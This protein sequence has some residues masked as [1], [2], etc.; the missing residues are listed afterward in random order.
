MKKCVIL[1][2]VL[3]FLSFPISSFGEIGIMGLKSKDIE[4]DFF[5][6]LKTYPTFMR[7]VDFNSNATKYDFILDENGAMADHSIRNELRIGWKGK[8]ENWDFLII[9]EGDFNLNK[10]NCDRGSD[11]TAA[12]FADDSG[13]SGEDFGIEK[14]NF[15]YDF[16]PFAVETGWNT[17]FLDIMTGGFLYGD[18]HP[19]IGLTGNIGSDFYW[20]LL[21]LIIQDDIDWDG[22]EGNINDGDSLDWRVYSIKGI[23]KLPDNFVISPFFAYSDNSGQRKGATN[24]TQSDVCFFGVEAY[25]QINIFTPRFEFVYANGD[26]GKTDSGDDYNINAWAA[27]A[28]VDAELDTSIIPYIGISYV[29]GDGDDNDDTI[30]AFNG[31][32]DIARYTPTFGMENAFIYRYIPVLGSGL[33]SHTFDGLATGCK[34]PG[35]GGIG[36]MGEGAA[37]GLIEYGAGVKGTIDKFAYKMQICY[38]NFEDEGG[39]EDIYGNSIDSEVGIEFDLRLAYQ[40]SNHFTLGNT[41]SLFKPGDGIQ[42]IHG[43]DYDRTAFLYTV[44]LVWRW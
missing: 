16:G 5:G 43:N 41:V 8:G 24:E 38:Y 28:S 7:N 10:A 32:T 14:L 6:S 9:L 36:N 1:S 31:I 18:D 11:R 2:M 42:D 17:R 19:Y 37:P 34:S 33:Y 29:S 40:F 15:T 3:A 22:G 21:Y 4:V 25:G 27:Y 23:Y 12:H 35:Y 44:E 20:E 26:T 30:N 13:M 39:L